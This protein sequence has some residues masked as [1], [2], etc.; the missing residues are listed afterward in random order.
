MQRWKAEVPPVKE[1][2][3]GSCW[4]HILIPRSWQTPSGLGNHIGQMSL[5]LSQQLLF[6][7]HPTLKGGKQDILFLLDAYELPAFL[8]ERPNSTK[9]P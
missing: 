4:F 9:S 3:L 7:A 2:S 6:K 1:P 5:L 8:A